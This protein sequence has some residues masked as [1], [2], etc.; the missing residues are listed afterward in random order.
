MVSSLHDDK[1]VAAELKADSPVKVYIY[2][3]T[4]L[5]CVFFKANGFVRS[6]DLDVGKSFSITQ[7][8]YIYHESPVAPHPNGPLLD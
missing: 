1:S 5:S 3:F 8:L 4:R 2:T 6:I 7:L